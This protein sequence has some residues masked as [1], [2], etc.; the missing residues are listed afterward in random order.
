M[1]TADGYSQNRRTKYLILLH[2]ALIKMV[3]E[4]RLTRDEASSL[5]DMIK[6]TDKESL[7]LALT[8][9]QQKKHTIFLKG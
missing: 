2:D 8:I 3:F 7:F 6:S 5:F 9:M 1:G 4:K